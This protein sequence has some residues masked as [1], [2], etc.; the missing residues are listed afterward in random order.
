[1]AEDS[2]AV[3]AAKE[4]QQIAEAEKLAAESRLA[5]AKAEAELA[6]YGDLAKL[7]QEKAL[8]DAEAAVLAKRKAASDAEAAAIAVEQANIKAKFG[9]VAANTV[10]PGEVTANAGAGTLEA[11][12][13]SARAIDAIG[14]KI[15]ADILKVNN[16]AGYVIFTGTERPT[17]GN[18]R[19]FELRHDVISKMF[20]K[21]DGDSNAAGLALAKLKSA[22]P[23]K[24][25]GATEAAI[26]A[27]ITGV[28]AALDSLAKI[29]SYFQ[30]SYTVSK[31][32]VTGSDDNLLVMSVA[33]GMAGKGVYL[34]GRWSSPDPSAAN[35]KLQALSV[36]RSN[37]AGAVVVAKEQIKAL[38]DEATKEKNEARK[39]QILEVV[40]AY[41]TAVASHEL[42]QK[43]FD[44][45]LVALSTPDTNGVALISKVADE[46]FIREK[47]TAKASSVFLHVHAATG[48]SYTKKNLWTF[49]GGMPFYVAGGAVASYVVMDH[50]GKVQKAGQFDQHGGYYK[51][52]QVAP[53]TP[54]AGN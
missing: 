29:A 43:T 27:A 9:S 48:A 1:M 42:A 23:I 7:N 18:L 51:P 44:D 8:A 34:P 49:F 39:A 53:K 3:T 13:L 54:P 24:S 28:G 30:S 4:A 6:A 2:A 32:D 19:V 52:N 10:T 35:T 11:N 5:K 50:E 38:Q 26:G 41:Q 22:A 47:I 37:S 33:N 21:A 12:L 15:S 16:A 46:S 17:F 25:S 40:A 20:D 36:S 14:A 45:F 31:V